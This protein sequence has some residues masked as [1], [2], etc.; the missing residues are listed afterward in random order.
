MAVAVTFVWV[1]SA[2]HALDSCVI[3]DVL[4][5]KEGENSFIRDVNE[6][7]LIAVPAQPV[8]ASSGRPLDFEVTLDG[9]TDELTPAA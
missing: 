9:F 1:D 7:T 4:P 6:V 8:F 3:A 2:N 5:F